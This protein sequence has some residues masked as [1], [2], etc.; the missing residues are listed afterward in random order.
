[1]D[2][3]ASIKGVHDGLATALGDGPL[4]VLMD[5]LAH[6]LATRER[7]FQDGR[8]AVNSG[9]RELGRAELQKISDLVASHGMVLW[10]VLSEHAGTQEAARKLELGTSLPGSGVEL[11]GGDRRLEP[12]RSPAG[13]ERGFRN[14]IAPADR[15]F[16]VTNPE[17]SSVRDSDRMVGLVEAGEK[18]APSLIVHRLKPEM[19]ARGDMLDIGDVLDVLMIELIGIVPEDEQ[20]L[21]ATNHGQPTALEDHSVAGQPSATSPGELSARRPRSWRWSRTAVCAAW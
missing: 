20:V 17:V 12:S 13:I 7:F 8:A 4:D 16:V 1:M 5:D 18:G 3:I 19:I 21:I 10:A 15:V 11:A 9:E 6:Q 14:A 2:A